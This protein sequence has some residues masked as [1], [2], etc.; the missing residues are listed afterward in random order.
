MISVNE[1]APF[2]SVSAFFTES[3]FEKSNKLTSPFTSIAV[4]VRSLI[5]LLN[6]PVAVMI[7]F[8]MVPDAEVISSK[9][10]FVISVTGILSPV[11][12]TSILVVISLLSI[13]GNTADRL[14]GIALFFCA[15]IA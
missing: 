8:A 12:K 9:G 13:S 3:T 5:L 1:N 6:A 2:E 4:T 15:F 11:P 14:M 7:L 10:F